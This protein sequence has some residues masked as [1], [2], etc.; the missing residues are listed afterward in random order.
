VV[1]A[2]NARQVT[3]SIEGQSSGVL[4][5]PEP[6][7]M[8]RRALQRDPAWLHPP[9]LPGRHPALRAFREATRAAR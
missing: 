1:I 4:S 8:R 2:V 3:N 7:A 6:R 9:P 5:E